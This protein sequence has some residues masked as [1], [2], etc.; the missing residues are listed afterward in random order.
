MQGTH[1]SIHENINTLGLAR[2]RM[3]NDYFEHH[4]QLFLYFQYKDI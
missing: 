4:G 2:K 3:A 1:I